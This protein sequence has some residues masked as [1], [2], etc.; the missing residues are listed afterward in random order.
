MSIKD[1]LHRTDEKGWQLG[2]AAT[3]SPQPSYGLRDVLGKRVESTNIIKGGTTRISRY[4]WTE[5]VYGGN[6]IN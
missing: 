6:A 1:T 3:S 5:Y 4:C 2:N